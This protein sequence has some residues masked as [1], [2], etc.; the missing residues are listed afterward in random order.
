MWKVLLAALVLTLGKVKGDTL[1]Q[2]IQ[3]KPELSQAL[4]WIDM[5]NTLVMALNSTEETRTVLLPDNAAVDVF[6][7]TFSMLLEADPPKLLNN[8]A[9][10][11]NMTIEALAAMKTVQISPTE[12]TT[13]VL[14]FS[15]Q[16]EDYFVNNAKVKSSNMMASNGYLHILDQV[17]YPPS[18]SQTLTEVINTVNRYSGL[19]ELL[20]KVTTFPWQEG[21]NY[22][23]F[24]PSN[25]VITDEIK[26][27]NETQLLPVLQQHV[28]TAPLFTRWLKMS[29][30]P[31][32]TLNADDKIHVSY[33]DETLFVGVNDHW[34]IVDQIDVNMPTTNG[35]IH[36]INAVIGVTPGVSVYQQLSLSNMWTE[37]KTKLLGVEAIKTELMKADQNF[38][39]LAPSA[40]AWQK[41]KNVEVKDAEMVLKRHVLTMS[42][43]HAQLMDKTEVTTFGGDK[44]DVKKTDGKIMLAYT[45]DD[46]TVEATVDDS[47]TMT[48]NGYIYKIDTVLYIKSGAWRN[49]VSFTTAVFSLVCAIV[50]IMRE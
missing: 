37:T 31:L 39:L 26:A 30:D 46:S 42:L 25:D 12:N 20:A 47:G 11:G 44:L 35:V 23:V 43:T 24:V 13:A 38:T 16:M 21:Q 50:F 29:S 19:K 14:W 36:I 27:M 41:M 4:T 3:S 1:Y 40:A 49:G 48:T 8:A 34:A 7:Q 5:V 2:M 15:Q 33:M 28:A 32:N 45:K 9:V 10:P 18:D 22:T 17:L 6:N